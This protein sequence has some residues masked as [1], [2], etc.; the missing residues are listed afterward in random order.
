LASESA[1]LFNQILAMQVP[2][3]PNVQDY[4]IDTYSFD[5]GDD[6]YSFSD[7]VQNSDGTYKLNLTYD[8]DAI[9]ASR[10]GQYTDAT[11]SSSN[12]L[13]YNGYSCTLS[14]ADI[15]DEDD[16]PTVMTREILSK[17][18]SRYRRLPR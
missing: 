5:D 6:E 16:D 11:I 15:P 9:Q 1:D 17:M 18:D 7:P 4:Y 8:V 13:S 3:T 10:T 2:T 12:V 14:V